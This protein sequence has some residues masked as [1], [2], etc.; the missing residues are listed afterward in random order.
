M[1]DVVLH[2]HLPVGTR[3]QGKVRDVYDLGD[4]LLLVSTD[5]ISAFDWIL[6]S[7]IPRKGYVLTQLSRFWFDRLPCCHHVLSYNPAHAGIVDPDLLKMLAGRSVLCRKAKVF[8]IECVVRGYLAGSGWKEYQRSQAVCGVALPPGLKLSSKL[9]EP[10]FTPATKAQA[11]HD[12]NITFAQVVEQIGEQYAAELKSRSIELYQAAALHA[13]T[14][15]MLVADTKFEWGLI[16]G[17][18]TLV[19]EALTPDSSRYWDA[20]EYEP[21]RPQEAFDKQ[22]V[23]DWLETTGWDKQSP[24]PE[25]PAEIVSRTTDKYL[26]VYQRLTG[27]PLTITT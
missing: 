4:R 10:I 17:E 13:A 27:H 25:L 21:G 20:A 1:T 6:P 8:P 2:T 16:D 7:G 3:Y 19:D 5:R 22:L 23:R 9:P 18:L 24:P 15:G 14:R 26:E 12:E 11:G